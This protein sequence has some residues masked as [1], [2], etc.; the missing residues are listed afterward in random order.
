MRFNNV[1]IV[2][3]THAN[4]SEAENLLRKNYKTAPPEEADVV[5][6][7]GGDGFML[8]TMHKFMEKKVPIYGMNLGTVG[9]L[10][11]EYRT[12]GLIE[13]LE[14]SEKIELRPLTMTANSSK[15]DAYTAL[16]INEVSLLRETHHAAKVRILV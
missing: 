12:T 7:L 9:F 16:A 6:A 10:M 13:R 5:V 8:S 4:A 15:G 14:V 11:N 1:T 3:D 2:A